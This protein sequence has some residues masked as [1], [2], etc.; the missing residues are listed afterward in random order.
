[1]QQTMHL[2]ESI[3][4]IYYFESVELPD[5]IEQEYYQLIQLRDY[6]NIT[7]EEIKRLNEILTMSFPVKFHLTSFELIRRNTDQPSHLFSISGRNMIEIIEYIDYMKK[8]VESKEY[9]FLYA[10]DEKYS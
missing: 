7:E 5:E 6:G 4:V 3:A 10:L 8:D 1:M 9:L 2:G